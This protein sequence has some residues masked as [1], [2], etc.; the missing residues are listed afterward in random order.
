[1]KGTKRGRTPLSNIHTHSGNRAGLLKHQSPVALEMAV[2]DFAT[3]YKAREIVTIKKIELGHRS[4]A[5]DAP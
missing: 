5:K 3:V 2:G 1:M 4:E